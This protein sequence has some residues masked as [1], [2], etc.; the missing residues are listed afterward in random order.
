MTRRTWTAM[1][2]ALAL[3][4]AVA[5]AAAT[6]YGSVSTERQGSTLS[7]LIYLVLAFGSGS[8][9]PLDNLPP[10]MSRIAP[11]SPFYWGTEGFKKLLQGASLP[12]I[13]GMVLALGLLGGGLLALGSVLL[14]RRILRGEAG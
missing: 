13:Q 7:S 2:G 14:H 8:F 9:I 6:I 12:E 10:V 1:A 4:L 11:F 5:G 3:V